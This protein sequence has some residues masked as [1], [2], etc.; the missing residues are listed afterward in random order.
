MCVT[1]TAGTCTYVGARGGAREQRFVRGGGARAQNIAHANAIACSR[2]PL[3]H[4]VCV[5][6]RVVR[7]TARAQDVLNGKGDVHNIL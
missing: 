1:K 2:F 7:E 3:T 6:F 5:A 4:R